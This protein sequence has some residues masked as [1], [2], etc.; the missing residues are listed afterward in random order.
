ML[1]IITE[2]AD[3][4]NRNKSE[5][6]VIYNHKY[7]NSNFN[8]ETKFIMCNKQNPYQVSIDER[9]WAL[10]NLSVKYTIYAKRF[11][12][13]RIVLFG[14]IPYITVIRHQTVLG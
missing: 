10:Q 14:S 3:F 12:K 4:C 7:F 13:S 8:S 1:T 11:S 5:K 9:L 6:A 2:H